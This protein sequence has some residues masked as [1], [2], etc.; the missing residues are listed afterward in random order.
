MSVESVCC[1]EITATANKMEASEFST[2]QCITKHVGFDAVC[3]N[4]W[5]LEAC[6]SHRQH[7]AHRMLELYN[8]MSKFEL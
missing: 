5:V 7:M 3:L 2:I 4:V 1:R 8:N 6:Y